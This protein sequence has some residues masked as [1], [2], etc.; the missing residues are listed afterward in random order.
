MFLRGVFDVRVNEERVG[1]AVDIFDGDLETVEASGFGRCDFCVEV[2]AE[3][4]ID[5]AI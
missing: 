2:A 1:F 5:N 3:V 4:F